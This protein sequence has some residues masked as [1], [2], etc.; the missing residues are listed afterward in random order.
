MRMSQGLSWNSLCSSVM[1]KEN[2]AFLQFRVK[3]V[4]VFGGLAEQQKWVWSHCGQDL[5]RVFWCVF[6]A[7]QFLWHIHAAAWCIWGAWGVV[8]LLAMFFQS[9]LPKFE[10]FRRNPICILI[11]GS[12]VGRLNSLRLPDARDLSGKMAAKSVALKLK[13]KYRSTRATCN[14]RLHTNHTT[15][16]CNCTLPEEC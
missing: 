1:T 10:W 2:Q 7:V 8:L 13:S 4:W 14:N 12:E 5:G 15:T 11:S 6:S 16:K 9:H 3:T